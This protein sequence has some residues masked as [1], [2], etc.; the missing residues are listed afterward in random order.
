MSRN[1]DFSGDI[2]NGWCKT[3]SSTKTLSFPSIISVDN[4]SV[5]FSPT[6]S[7][8]GD[9]IIDF[10]GE[11]YAIGSTVHSRGLLPITISD[12]SRIE[13]NF[14]R[15]LVAAG[16]AATIP[17]TADINAVFSLPPGAYW[18]RERYRE[19]I[20]G[21]YKVSLKNGK[22][23][24]Y[25]LDPENL[26]IIP[27][28]FGTI[29]QLVL[30]ENGKTN[31]DESG[32]PDNT[33]FQRRVG[34]VDVG[35]NT[36]DL[37]FFENMRLIQ[38]GTTSLPR[39]GITTLHN[40]IQ[41]AASR[42]SVDLRPHQLDKVMREGYFLKNGDRQN[43]TGLIEDVATNQLAQA[44][45]GGIRQHWNGGNDAEF[46]IL[47]GG[48]ADFVFRELANMFGKRVYIIEEDPHFANCSGGYRYLQ[49][50]NKARK[51]GK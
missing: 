7:P 19:I 13:Q 2:G 16:L 50:N 20:S 1:R 8:N 42:H 25:T 18:D 14:Y 15:V 31:L 45:G 48:G 17:Q 33:L 24:T 9:F 34:V 30:D 22:T 10:E 40:R 37:L 39:T 49:L 26:R 29:C 38:S 47:T 28:G 5:D 32:K 11:T 6:F 3:M 35:T 51:N 36:T 43:I 23:F 44:I 21:T 27:E 46:I 12:R 41:T 4:Q